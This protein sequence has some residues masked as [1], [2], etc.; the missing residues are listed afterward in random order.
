MGGP[1][2]LDGRRSKGGHNNQPKVVVNGEGGIREETR[3]G[4]NVWGSLSYCLGHQMEASDKKN[5]DMGW[6][7]GVDGCR[8]K[9]LHTTMNQKQ[10][11]ATEGTMK[12]RYNEREAWGK[13]DTIVFGRHYS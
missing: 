9:I 7:L 6:A 11:A 3:P 10:V 12:G 4:R 1:L 2:A 5:R 13:H 8:L